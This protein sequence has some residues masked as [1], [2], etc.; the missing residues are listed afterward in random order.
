MAIT[1]K[2]AQPRGLVEQVRAAQRLPA[3]TVT[4]AIRRAAGVSQQQIADELGV[5]RV[6]VARYEIVERSPRGELRL[7]YIEL[8]ETLRELT[9]A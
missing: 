7:R 2:G 4:R 1:I 9:G 3:P 5:N 8:L 6:T